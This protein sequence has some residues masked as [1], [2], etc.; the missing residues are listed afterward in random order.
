MS[1]ISMSM[2][3]SLVLVYYQSST[4]LLPRRVVL[5]YYQSST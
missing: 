3:T 2:S 4:S 5:V 1:I